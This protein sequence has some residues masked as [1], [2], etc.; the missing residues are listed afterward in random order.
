[1]LGDLLLW[2]KLICIIIEFLLIDLFIIILLVRVLL[3]K[4]WK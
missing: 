2:S 1:M 4:F 3:V